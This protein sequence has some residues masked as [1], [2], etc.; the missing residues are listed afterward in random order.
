M[1]QRIQPGIIIM[2]VFTNLTA[3]ARSDITETFLDIAEIMVD[4][5][6]SYYS[7]PN[8]IRENLW[9][10]H[11][12]NITAFKTYSITDPQPYNETISAMSKEEQLMFVLFAAAIIA[13]GDSPE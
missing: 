6:L 10:R 12:F 4:Q 9:N 5:N 7:T 13:A 3:S 8:D 2:S 11:R 1:H